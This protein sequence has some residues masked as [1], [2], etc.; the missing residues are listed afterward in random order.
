MRQ[1]S[2]E[3]LNGLPP[4][5]V[6]VTLGEVAQI[7]SGT[8][9]P[10]YLQG[11]PEGDIPF[12]KV[13]DIS[14][15]VESG[16]KYLVSAAHFISQEEAYQLRAE[17]LPT[18]S[19]VFA[20]IGGAI[21]LNRRVLLKRPFIVDNNVM[22]AI[23]ESGIEPLYL[24]YFMLTQHLGKISRATTVP[25][26]RKSDIESLS[27]PVPPLNEQRR[28]ASTLEELFSD[29]D[30]GV[31]ALQKAQTKLK[32]YRAAVLKVAVGGQLT[33]EWRKQHPRTESASDLLKRV[34]ADRRRRWDEEQLQRF[35]EKGAEPPRGWQARY[36]EPTAARVDDLP[37]LPKNWCWATL[38]QLSTEIRNGYSLKPTATAGIPILRISS[39]RPLA[40]DMHDVRY[41]PGHINH[42]RSFNLEKDDL[43]FT[44]YNGTRSLVG[45]CAAV[46]FLAAPL[47]HPDKL[48]RVRLQQ[49][50]P[51]YV[52]LAA[53]TG[54]SR[55]FLESR[56]RTTAGQAGISGH[57]LKELP[58]PLAPLEEQQAIAELIDEQL[59]MIDYVEA[60]IE[61]KLTASHS[62]RQSIL[63]RA[64]TGQLVP[65]DP[66]DE[67]A[68]ELLKRIAAERA[69]HSNSKPGRRAR[70]A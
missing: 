11:R 7:R 9:F 70:N 69:Q 20:K 26:L 6:K 61:T 58:I 17:P 65:Q 63:H 45:V 37:P 41:L 13:S 44:R 39:V 54:I 52:A 53:N 22:G 60:D 31:E 10:V 8:G 42:Y 30:A 29:L 15:A 23:P 66:D 59:S 19:V 32:L 25:S 38:D 62:L 34:L 21:E 14:Q 24:Y 4:S 27:I 28:I 64:F 3:L 50:L 68:S 43:L 1:T 47:V 57:D 67:S 16:S 5:W 33:A 49:S 12:A 55:K 18:N 35:A 46:P 40:L 48:I 56:I 51:A 2:T 36:P